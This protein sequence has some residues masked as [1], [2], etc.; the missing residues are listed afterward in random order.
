MCATVHLSASRPFASC[1][2]AEAITQSYK[3]YAKA[4]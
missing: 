2:T 3:G 4:V 1:P